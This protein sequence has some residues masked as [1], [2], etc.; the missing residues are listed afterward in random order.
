MLPA[1]PYF[2]ARLLANESLA[3]GYFVLRLGDCE[4][5]ADAQPGQFV[6]LRGEWGC[7]PLLPRAFSLLR[8]RQGGVVDILGKTV[9]KASALLEHAQRGARFFL[10]GPLGVGYPAPEPGIRDLLVAGGVGLAPL[11]FYAE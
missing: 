11:L 10:L 4:P 2:P 7:D 9:G 5:L 3:S 6:M 1:V 8:T